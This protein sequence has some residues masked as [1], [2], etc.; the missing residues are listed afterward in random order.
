VPTANAANYCVELN[1]WRCEVNMDPD[2]LW[3][4][5]PWKVGQIK[6]PGTGIMS[7]SLLN[8]F[9]ASFDCGRTPSVIC[10]RVPVSTVVEIIVMLE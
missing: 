7:C 9:A 2:E 6:N 4:L 1:V 3:P 5:W 8:P 10:L